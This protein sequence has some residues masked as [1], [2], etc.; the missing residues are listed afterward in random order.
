MRE[1]KQIKLSC[2]LIWSAPLRDGSLSCWRWW[3]RSRKQ[4]KHRLKSWLKSWSRKSLNSREETLSW[5]SSHTLKITC[6]SYRSV[7]L[8]LLTSQDNTQHAEAFLCSPALHQVY[9]SVCSPPE[10]KSW[11]NIN[12]NTDLLNTDILDEALTSLKEKVNKQLKKIHDI[13]KQYRCEC[14]YEVYISRQKGASLFRTLY[15]QQ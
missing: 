9:S 14:I 4:Q 3:S 2:S 7:F 13:C 11:T 12:I 5:S 15:P 8:S 1:I 10:V 6:T